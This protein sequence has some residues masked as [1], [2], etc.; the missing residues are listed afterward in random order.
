MGVKAERER[1]KRE[2]K[3]RWTRRGGEAGGEVQGRKVRH[4]TTRQRGD[5]MNPD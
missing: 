5:A 3:E 1:K 2:E 4:V